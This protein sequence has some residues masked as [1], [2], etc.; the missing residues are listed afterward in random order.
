MLFRLQSVQSRNSPTI[1]SQHI[2][3]CWQICIVYQLFYYSPIT[4]NGSERMRAT[5]ATRTIYD[6]LTPFVFPFENYARYRLLFCWR[7]CEP[8]RASGWSVPIS[9]WARPRFKAY[10]SARFC[11]ITNV[12]PH[13]QQLRKCCAKL[14]VAEVRTCIF[15]TQEH[16][17]K[18]RRRKV[19][20]IFTFDCVLP[21][22]WDFLVF[23]FGEDGVACSRPRRRKMKSRDNLVTMSS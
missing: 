8:C 2:I 12:E 18:C 6:Q 9:L 15:F 21:L 13:Y 20:R 3:H 5:V 23:E 17:R 10:L 1:H 22:R 7:C 4:K 11:Y 16:P 14:L 19:L